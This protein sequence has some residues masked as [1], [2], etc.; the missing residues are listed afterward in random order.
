MM[1]DGHVA[2]VGAG[3]I[4]RS[5][6]VAFARGGYTVKMYDPADGAAARSQGLLP[7]MLA[8]LETNDLLRGQKAS[9][10]LARISVAP[11]LE[12]AVRG[13]AY[14]Q[15]N[16]PENRDIKAALYTEM[17]ALVDDNC[18][19]ASSTSAI[20]PSLF[21]GHIKHKA[22]CIVA[23]PLN[24]PH[25]IP[26][27]E[28]VPAP[29]TDP[30]ITARTKAIQEAIG[31]KPIVMLKE[32]KGFLMNRLQG[33]VLEECLRLVEGGYVT[34]EEIDISVKH[35]LA[36]RWAFIG[37]IETMDL[38]APGGV[39]DYITKFGNTLESLR[40]GSKFYTNWQGPVK[41]RLTEQ[42]TALLPRDKILERQNWRDRMLMQLAGLKKKVAG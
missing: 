40:D 24:P 32:I 35:G 30:A 36:M 41:D 20:L 39:H 26:A 7:A 34:A 13:A 16:A 19:I 33:A 5:W 2:I 31:Q 17:D 1:A 3:L 18:V 38:N 27:I 42:R 12:S 8:E 28:I 4:G 15:E 29:W 25:L 22:Q 10:V 23:H 37:P 14:I 9:D 11:T 6:T 21:T